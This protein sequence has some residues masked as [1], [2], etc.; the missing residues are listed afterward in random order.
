VSEEKLVATTNITIQ[1]EK[2][3]KGMPLDPV[4]YTDF[5]KPEYKKHK[6]GAN[7][8]RECILEHYEKLLRVVQRY[9]T[10][11]GKFDKVYQYHKRILMHFTGK[12][13]LNLPFY[14]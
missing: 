3:F 5:L 9:F 2:W 6:F 13:P 4:F 8:P 12:N 1:G 7:I 11:E 10:C 14:L